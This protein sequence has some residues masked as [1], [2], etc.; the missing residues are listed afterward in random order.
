MHKYEEYYAKDGSSD[1]PV[2]AYK[3]DE[4]HEVSTIGGV[5]V[6]GDGYVVARDRAELVDHFPTKDFEELYSTRKPSDNTDDTEDTEIQAGGTN[7]D[8]VGGED[9]DPSDKTQTE[10]LA[11]MRQHPEQVDAVKARERAGQSRPKVLEFR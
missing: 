5:R 9:Y 3:V 2:R 7:A 1:E 4:Q 6:V 10:V 8:P 11:Y